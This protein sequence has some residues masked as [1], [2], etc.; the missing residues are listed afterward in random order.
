LVS[1]FST[2]QLALTYNVSALYNRQR[3]GENMKTTALGVSF[4]IGL[5]AAWSV[6]SMAR[7]AG[8]GRGGRGTL[9]AAA[10]ATPC[11][12][13]ATSTGCLIYRLDQIDKRLNALD[14]SIADLQARP[15]RGVPS[16]PPISDIVQP[17]GKAD[18]TTDYLQQRIDAITKVVTQLVDRV[19]KL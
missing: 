13:A 7:Q 14:T 3:S 15:A 18:A 5:V 16:G 9:A 1:N 12:G 17:G 8:Q 2:V 4:A 11:T 10:A 6:E 19:N